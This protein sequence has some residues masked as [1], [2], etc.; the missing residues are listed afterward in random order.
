MSTQTKKREEKSEKKPLTIAQQA[1]YARRKLKNRDIEFLVDHRGRSVPVDYVP[2]IDLLKHFEAL[3]IIDRA[4]ELARELAEFKYEVQQKGDD[5]HDQ[6]MAENEIRD[7]SVGGFTL[8]TFSKELK[9]I[10]AMDTVQVKVQEELDM[11]DE[12]WSKFLDDEFDEDTKEKIGWMIEIVD[13]L[14][15]NTKGQIDTRNIGRLNRMAS[16]IP[17]D[18]YHKFLKHLNQAYDTQHTKRYEQFKVRNDQGEYDSVLLTY[19]RISPLDPDKGE[20]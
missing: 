18:K 5:L 8:A 16:K 13:E 2:D 19:S 20:A 11:A 10:F 4:Q 3:E 17:N 1:G 7:N 9:V 14:L 6:L 15:H 12:W